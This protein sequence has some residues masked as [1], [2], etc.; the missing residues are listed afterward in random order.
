MLGRRIVNAAIAA[1]LTAAP[2]V[3]QSLGDLARQEEAR[4]TSVQQAAKK[5]SNADLDPSAIVAPSGTAPA[6]ASC[7]FSKSKGH[8]VSAE[9]MASTSA[10]GVLTTENAPFEQRWRT[11]AE[12]IRSQLEKTHDSI[13]TL[14]AVLADEGRSASDRKAIEKTLAG[15]R[16]AL[17][18]FERQWEKL[19]S[20]AANQR[21]PRAWIEPV[22]ALTKNQPHQ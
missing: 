22:P 8:C 15:A 1:S 2:A 13:A 18:G 16:Q 21:I 6:E 7:Y 10:A 4:R 20:N 12:S 3:A 9:E 19:E 17:A 14:E 11:D 5:L